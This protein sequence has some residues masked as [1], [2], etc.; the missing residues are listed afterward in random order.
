MARRI[1][2]VGNGDIE[3]S[4]AALI[5]ACDL[6]V[7]FNQCVSY[8]KGGNRC[9]VVAVCNM[10]R[11]GLAMIHSR[12]WRAHP[13]VQAASQIWSVRDARKFDEMRADILQREPG[14]TDFFDDYTGDFARFARQEGK[15]HCLIPRALHDN[16]DRRL[17][18]LSSDPYIC[19]ST[20]LIAIAHVLK[21]IAKKGDA[22]MI[23]GFSHQGW[24]GHPFAAERQLLDALETEGKISRVSNNIISPPHKEL[25]IHAV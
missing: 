3:A 4:S 12:E 5:D 8:G 15:H 2:V 22:V 11:P 18:A 23:A 21:S 7:R 13:A 10:G 24:S 17:S 14:L 20:G 9:D 6:V 1:A 16:L 25:Y 19:P